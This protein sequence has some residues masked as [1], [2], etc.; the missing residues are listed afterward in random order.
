MPPNPSAA[1]KKQQITLAQL[2]SYDDILTDALVDHVSG[3]T[4]L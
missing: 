4:R 3:N 2:S 1:L